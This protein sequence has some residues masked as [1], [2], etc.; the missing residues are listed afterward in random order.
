[1]FSDMIVEW[2]CV[3]YVVFDGWSVMIVKI[4]FFF[5][6]FVGEVL[7]MEIIDFVIVCFEVVVGIVC[8]VYDVVDEEDLIFVDFLYVIIECFE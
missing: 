1:M 2:M 4:L 3:L 5:E 7:M 6:F 8:D